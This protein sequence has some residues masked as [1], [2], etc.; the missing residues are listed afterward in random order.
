LAANADFIYGSQQRATFWFLNVAPQWQ[1]FN[2]ANW[3]QLED[4]A[5]DYAAGSG[6]DVI[7]YTGTHGVTTLDDVN[8]NPAEIYVG[9]DSNGNGVLRVPEFYWKIVYEPSTQKVKIS[10]QNMGNGKAI[11]L[12]LGMQLGRLWSKA[13]CIL[14]LDACYTSYKST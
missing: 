13:G 7:V 8:G 5:R 11:T 2:G 3:A 10:K 4:S 6:N 9:F 1:S 12:T 14:L